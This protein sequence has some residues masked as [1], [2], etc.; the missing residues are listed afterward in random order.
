VVVLRAEAYVN[1]A[2]LLGLKDM[3]PALSGVYIVLAL[4][5]PFI[6]ETLLAAGRHDLER[7]PQWLQRRNRAEDERVAAAAMRS[8]I[9]D[10]VALEPLTELNMQ[11]IM[12]RLEECHNLGYGWDGK[13]DSAFVTERVLAQAANPTRTT[14]RAAL[15]YLDLLYQYGRP[16]DI[17]VHAP[18][19]GS[20]EEDSR[21]EGSDTTQDQG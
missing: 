7:V 10:S 18:D 6:A 21:F 19:T 16:P 15:E 17:A 5:T 11:A 8:L 4:A 9:Q 20:L 1:L 13:L 12:T 14:I 2:I 3:Q